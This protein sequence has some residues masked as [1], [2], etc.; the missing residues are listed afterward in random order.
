[1]TDQYIEYITENGKSISIQSHLI[2][3]DSVQ[4]ING[5]MDKHFAFYEES[6]KLPES[7][8]AFKYLGEENSFPEE[9]FNDEGD[10]LKVLTKTSVFQIS[11]KDDGIIFITD[12]VNGIVDLWVQQS[13]LAN[14]F[15]SLLDLQDEDSEGFIATFV[16]LYLANEGKAS[17]NID[18]AILEF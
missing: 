5:S 3:E 1:M 10:Y 15:M 18:A 13:A 8:L 17:H 12:T 7:F 16:E 11:F 6:D 4:K 14:G 9:K 2:M